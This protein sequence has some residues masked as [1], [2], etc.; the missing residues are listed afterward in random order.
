MGRTRKKFATYAPW[1][2]EIGSG[3]GRSRPEERHSGSG[4]QVP[5]GVVA[6]WSLAETVRAAM[7]SDVDGCDEACEK[8]GDVSDAFNQFVAILKQIERDEVPPAAK[9]GGSSCSPP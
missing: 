1:R 5:V 4:R 7:G 3:S 9:I 2:V 6:A 8:G